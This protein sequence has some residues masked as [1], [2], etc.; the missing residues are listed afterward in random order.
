MG[1]KLSIVILTKDTKNLLQ[2]LLDSIRKDRSLV[3]FISEIIVVDNASADGTKE[4]V[5]TGF[6]FVTYVQNE[7]NMGF[8]RAVNRGAGEA[9]GD[10]LLFLNSDTILIEGEFVKI[11]EFMD[12]NQDVAVCGPQLVYPDMKPQRSAAFVPSF[13]TEIVP[14]GLLAILSPTGH[15][16]AGRPSGGDVSGM[17]VDSVIGAAMFV[18]RSDFESLG[19]LDERYFFFLEETDFCVRAW[20]AD[21]RVVLMP[22]ASVVHLQGRTVRKSW[23]AGRIEYNISLSKFIRK[24]HSGLYYMAFAVVRFLKALAVALVLPLALGG[25]KTRMK[26]R[27][28]VMLVMWYLKGC[29]D[30]GG[31]RKGR[32]A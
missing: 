6:P 9:R 21:R 22:D 16:P 29:P 23:I 30:T 26:H 31:L 17:D 28:H 5:A 27:Y 11:I 2:D 32:N 18:R 14:S 19:G 13:L 15:R 7:I 25:E 1:N 3:P 20:K 12:R 10:Y 4:M 8:A 24:H